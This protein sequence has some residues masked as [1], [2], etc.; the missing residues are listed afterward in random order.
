MTALGCLE[1]LPWSPRLR[2]PDPLNLMSCNLFHGP[3][4]DGVEDDYPSEYAEENFVKTQALDV[5]VRYGDILVLDCTLSASSLAGTSRLYSSLWH[6]LLIK[7]I[8]LLECSDRA[9]APRL[10]IL[11]RSTNPRDQMRL[12]DASDAAV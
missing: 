10:Y 12:I 6:L 11:M 5:T 4:L 3:L 9:N 8:N 7:V 2:F 1:K